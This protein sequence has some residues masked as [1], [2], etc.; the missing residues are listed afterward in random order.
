MLPIVDTPTIQYVVE[1]AIDSGLTDIIIVI[2][3]GKRSIEEHF[4][5]NFELERLLEVQGKRDDLDS[6]RSM[7]DRADIHFIWQ[8]DQKG[9]G[10]AIGCASRHVGSEPFAVL[11]GDTILES[12]EKRPVIRQLVDTYQ[13]FKEPIVGLEEV[14]RSLVTRYGIVSGQEIEDDTFLLSDLVEKPSVDEAPSNLAIASRFILTPAIFEYLSKIRPE[15]GKEVQLTDA[16][17]NLLKVG[18]IYGL[19]VAGVRHDIGN[20]LDF[21]KTSILYGLKREDIGPELREWI[22]KLVGDR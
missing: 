14:D 11:L 19:R 18:A 13:R 12:T 6:I 21:L 2:G 10:D 3:R 8:D 4:G 17:R 20:K 9:L 1:E 7:S 22:N 16:L 5:R 15:A